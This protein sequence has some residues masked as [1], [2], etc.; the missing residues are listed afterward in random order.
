MRQK[1]IYSDQEGKLLP[2]DE[3]YQKYG[4]NTRGGVSWQVMPDI[5]PYQSIIDGREITSRNKHRQ[6]L[7]DNGCVE[8]GNEKVKPKGI[9]D[10]P[11]RREEIIKTCH[12][13]GVFK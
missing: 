7:K 3:Y 12:E 10:V 5:S 4:P 13:L 8:I 6:H 2:A 11:G 9:P 1:Y